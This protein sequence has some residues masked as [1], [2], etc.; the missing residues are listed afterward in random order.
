MGGPGALLDDAGLIGDHGGEV[1]EQVTEL[2]AVAFEQLGSGA[3]AGPDPQHAVLRLAALTGVVAVTAAGRDLRLA[4]FGLADR[5]ELGERLGV[6][7]VAA[8]PDLHPRLVEQR[9]AHG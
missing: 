5:V 1:L 6:A 3:M 7:A 8:A 4:R 9:G 2:L